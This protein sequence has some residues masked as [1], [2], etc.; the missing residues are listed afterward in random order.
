MAA[1]EPIK[2]NEEAVK[3]YGIHLG[4]EMCRKILATGISSI[5]LY[6]LNVEKS[7]L[8]ILMVAFSHHY[9]LIYHHILFNTPNQSPLNMAE[10]WGDR[11]DQ[12]VESLALETPNKCVSCKRRCSSYFLVKT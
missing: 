1:L 4:T 12:S 10:P 9:Q 6:T 7:A 5:H 11:R 2:D 8:A 3:A